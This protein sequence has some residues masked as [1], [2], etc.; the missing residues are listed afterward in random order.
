[1][2][3]SHCFIEA[4]AFVTEFRNTVELKQPAFAEVK[5]AVDRLL[6]QADLL[7]GQTGLPHDDFDQARFAVCAW[8]DEM[9]GSGPW[10]HRQLWLKDQLQRLHFHTTE[11]GE[12]FFDRLNRLD[13]SQGEV[14]EVYYLCLALGF[15]GRFCKPGDHYQLEQLKL[16]NLKLLSGGSATM[17]APDQEELFPAAY[18]GTEPGKGAPRMWRPAF[19]LVNAACLI[20]P[21]LLFVIL[22][23]TYRLSLNTVSANLLRTVTN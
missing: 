18:P 13:A 1:M 9:L 16:A 8:I 10:E 21:L 19:S 23:L 2:H 12:E 11:A 20:G 14:R 4:F 15:T 5:G 17:L 7:A 3:L 22:F 6:A